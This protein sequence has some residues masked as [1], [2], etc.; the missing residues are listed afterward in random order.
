[1][2]RKG[3]RTGKEHKEGDLDVLSQGGKI[4]T[5]SLC[6]IFEEVRL[7]QCVLWPMLYTVEFIQICSFA[8]CLLAKYLI[9]KCNDIDKKVVD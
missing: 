9:K 3:N 4:T 6:S 5:T 8:G 2:W 1:M 7:L